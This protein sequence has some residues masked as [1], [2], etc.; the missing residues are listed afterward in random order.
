MARKK[1]APPESA[2]SPWIT[3]F[4]D[5]MNLLLC[6]FVL[7]FAMSTVDEGKYEDLIKSLS[8]GFSV[9]NSGTSV[10]DNGTSVV[11]NGRIISSGIQQLENLDQYSYEEG[12]GDSVLEGSESFD[13]ELHNK[14][15]EATEGIYDEII[16]ASKSLDIYDY[17]NFDM[18]P[19]FRFVQITLDGY[20]LF[21]PGKAE[22][23][24]DARVLISRIGDILKIFNKD[25][26]IEIEGH[27]DNV[28]ISRS[29][30]ETNELLSSAR[31]INAANFLIEEKGYNPAN[32]KWTGRG[33]YDPIVPNTT[34]EGRAMNRRIEIK[35]HNNVH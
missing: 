9:F 21:D 24:P 11:D 20:I 6:F 33:E 27:T 2:G 35:V 10:V 28:P 34:A 12:K 15:K 8:A 17:L 14:N 13:E 23:K 18:D 29:A 19:N 32:L 7:L 1:K 3:T 16:E 30:Y 31:A 4:A 5:L 22:I 25:Y 26:I